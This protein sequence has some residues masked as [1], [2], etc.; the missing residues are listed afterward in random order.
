MFPIN[1]FYRKYLLGLSSVNHFK[2]SS[3]HPI[4]SVARP[5][6]STCS[7][8]HTV[9]FARQNNRR[10]TRILA[11]HLSQK[12]KSH[13][14]VG[15]VATKTSL[16]RQHGLS[17]SHC[18]QAGACVVAHIHVCKALRRMNST[19]ITLRI[20]NTA[21]P[22]V[23]SHKRWFSNI[24]IWNGGLRC[25]MGVPGELW[26]TCSQLQEYSTGQRSVLVIL[27]RG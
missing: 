22:S 8:V 14:T 5:L 25:L 2:P 26:G 11:C 6:R 13:N 23:P 24:G 12:K 18:E 3:S 10:L 4:A 7:V 21:V 19:K 9:S 17:H 1:H 16:K 20:N 15:Q 27:W